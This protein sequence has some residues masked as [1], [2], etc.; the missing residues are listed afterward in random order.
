MLITFTLPNG[1]EVIIKEFLYKHIREL[2][3]QNNSLDSKLKY[4]EAFI[5]TQNLNVIEKFIVLLM[6]RKKC[7]KPSVTLNLNKANKE[8]SLDYIIESFE[9]SIDIRQE[10]TRDNIQLILD[11]PTKFCVNTD[12]VLS[13]IREIK[14]DDTH[15]VIDSL[16]EQ[17]FVQ[18][19]DNLPADILSVVSNFVTD[20]KDAFIFSLLSGRNNSMQ[21]NF[22]TPS[23]FQFIDTVFNCIDENSYREY[24]YILSKRI[25]DVQFLINSTMADILDYLELYR[26]ECED[27]GDKLKK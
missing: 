22:L 7:I 15:I 10:V 14:I 20:K 16:T 18:I 23:P 3:F 8:V 12:N 26:R 19:I 27:E 1:K 9:E 13:V 25:K 6:L 17:E 21:L 11:Y 4:L 2:L 24:L 5:V